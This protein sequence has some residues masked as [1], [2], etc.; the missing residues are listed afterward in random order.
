MNAPYPPAP[1][2]T[3]R[4]VTLIGA[5]FTAIGPVSMALYTPA[6]PEIVRAFGTT[7]AAVKMTLSLYFAGFAFAQ[8][9]C[10]PLSDGY[11][12]RPVTLAFMAIYLIA[13]VIALFS[14]NVET[15]ILARFLQGFGAA[16]GLAVSR[17]I[18]RDVFAGEASARILNVIGMILAVG[19]AFSPAL[20]GL[21]MQLF[22]WHSV[23]LLMV[24]LGVL[25]VWVTVFSLRE[26]VVRDPSRVRPGQLFGSYRTLLG[27]PYFMLTSVVAAGTVGAL[28]TQ[29]TLL[30]FILMNRVGLSPAAFGFGM[31]MQSGL[32]FLGTLAVR[33]AL[34]RTGAYRLVPAGLA[35][36]AL[37]SL[38]LAILLRMSAP[39]F[40]TVMGPVGC[41]AFGI[42]FVMPAI[43]TASLAPFP[44]I[45]GAASSLT[46]FLQ[47]GTG[48]LG[49]T[50]AAL[51]GDPVIALSTVIPAMGLTAICSWLLWRRLPDP[52]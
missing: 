27:S 45:A 16:V 33:F 38:L 30:P 19:P 9:V 24:L 2:M 1:A 44:R 14:P 48:L 20:G 22:G 7:E 41:Y 42:A 52:A 8:L 13:S 31:L 50:I 46:G 21:T 36:V 17:A 29:A 5:L 28:Y 34:P 35:F 23:F 40:L 15:L 26:T 43:L 3:A 10:G 25:V 18:V 51:I 4:R 39:T 47:M 12:R 37:G 49:G 6:M 11:G 32:F